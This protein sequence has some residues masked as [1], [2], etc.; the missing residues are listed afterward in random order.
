MHT[1]SIHIISFWLW[2]IRDA[3]HSTSS[4]TRVHRTCN[5]CS[6]FIRLYAL[7]ADAPLGCLN[8]S[9][10]FYWIAN[11][12]TKWN[13]HKSKSFE[14]ATDSGFF[15][16]SFGQNVLIYYLASC[17]FPTMGKSTYIA[18]AEDCGNSTQYS[19][20]RCMWITSIGHRTANL[21]SLK[22]IHTQTHIQYIFAMIGSAMQNALH[23]RM[24]EY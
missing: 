17:H 1:Y 12:K 10:I 14:T 8:T 7:C 18:V 16:R 22:H 20:A 19:I 5:M 15:F 24:E 4:H 11:I 2:H 21:Y 3:Q 23:N 13:G 6:F 9:L